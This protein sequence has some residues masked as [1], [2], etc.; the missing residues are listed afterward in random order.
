MVNIVSSKMAESHCTD[1]GCYACLGIHRSC[2]CVLDCTGVPPPFQLCL[3]HRPHPA[4]SVQRLRCLQ[5]CSL[6]Q[7]TLQNDIKYGNLSNDEAIHQRMLLCKTLLTA[8]CTDHKVCEQVSMSVSC[9]LHLYNYCLQNIECILTFSSNEIRIGQDSLFIQRR[10]LANGY[11]SRHPGTI[12]YNKPKTKKN[13]K[14]VI[15]KIV[16]KR[17]KHACKLYL[18]TLKK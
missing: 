15:I 7:W 9:T 16:Q 14:Y 12:Q 17:R 1:G 4:S 3:Y 11:Y 2:V 5:F 6:N 10:S 18:S 8:L 13:K